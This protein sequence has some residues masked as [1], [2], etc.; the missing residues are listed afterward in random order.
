MKINGLWAHN[1]LSD[2]GY[3]YAE[4]LTENEK[5]AKA[6][7]VK[8]YRTYEECYPWQLGK[9]DMIIYLIIG[10]LFIIFAV[11]GV[12]VE[13]IGMSI[14]LVAFAFLVWWIGVFSGNSITKCIR[15]R[16]EKKLAKV[17]GKRCVGEIVGYKIKADMLQFR[18]KGQ[19]CAD[20]SFTYVLE[21][22]FA[23][24]NRN[25]VIKTPDMRY[26]PNSVLKSNRCNVYRWNGKYYFADF[27]LRKKRVDETAAIPFQGVSHGQKW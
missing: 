26:H 11:F 16:E 6:R 21:V 27:D 9:S 14:F 23:E 3:A 22:R 10:I 25:R 15:L 8:A 18:F 20:F 19:D 13:K 7:V 4:A 17:N 2:K 1:G 12:M 5:R 24:G